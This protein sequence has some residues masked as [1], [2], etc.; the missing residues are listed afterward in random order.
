M[1][2][3][4]QPECGLNYYCDRRRGN[5]CCA[6]C[7]YSQGCNRKCLNSPERCGLYIGNNEQQ[8]KR[9]RPMGQCKYQLIDPEHNTYQCQNCG[10][11]ITLEADGPFENGM[12]FCPGCGREIKGGVGDGK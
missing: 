2:K 10:Y 1:R 8:T 3:K 7:G 4:R 9:S 11:I 5:Y 12:D 6:G